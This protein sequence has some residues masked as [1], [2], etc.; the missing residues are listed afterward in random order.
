[1][2]LLLWNGKYLHD[3]YLFKDEINT[4]FYEVDYQLPNMYAKWLWQIKNFLI[5]KNLDVL[6]ISKFINKYEL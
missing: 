3:F 2:G 5:V 1:M 6:D 4:D